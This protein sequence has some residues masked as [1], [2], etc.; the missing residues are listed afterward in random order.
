MEE[1][2]TAVGKRV[3]S[4]LQSRQQERNQSP[5]K[6]LSVAHVPAMLLLMPLSRARSSD[7]AIN[8]AQSRACPGARLLSVCPDVWL[9]DCALPS[10]AIDFLQ[11]DSR[12]SRQQI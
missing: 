8:A 7:A 4:A 12:L 2:G 10:S 11:P 3:V 5:A 6:A 9:S 1:G